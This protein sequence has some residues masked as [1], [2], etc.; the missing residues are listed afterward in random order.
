MDPVRKSDRSETGLERIQTDP[1]QYLFFYRS[2]SGTAEHICVWG[3][4]GGAKT[5]GHRE[6]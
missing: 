2:N 5:D 6:C 4:G 3:G 1:K